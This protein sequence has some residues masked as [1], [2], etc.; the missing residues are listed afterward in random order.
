MTRSVIFALFLMI[1]GAFPAMA[2]QCGNNTK[3]NGTSIT[4]GNVCECVSGAVHVVNAD[5]TIDPSQCTYCGGSKTKSEQ[6]IIQNDQCFQ[7][8]QN[9]VS[10]DSHETCVCSSD[11]FGYADAT[12][13]SCVICNNKDN[14]LDTDGVCQTCSGGYVSDNVCYTCDTETTTRDY[15][16]TYSSGYY[17]KCKNSGDAYTD[18]TKT[19]CETCA[20]TEIVDKESSSATYQMCVECE[21]GYAAG[22]VCVTCGEGTSLT[23][24]DNETYACTCNN[25]TGVAKKYTTANGKQHLTSC[26]LC[27]DDEY[28]AGSECIKCTGA[29]VPNANKDACIACAKNEIAVNGT[30]EPCPNGYRYDYYNTQYNQCVTC[31]EN[32]TLTPTMYDGAITGYNCV[33]NGGYGGGNV[34]QQTNG[35]GT[36]YIYSCT[37]CPD[38]QYSVNGYCRKCN[39]HQILNSDKTGCT[40]CG[41]LEIAV[42]TGTGESYSETCTAC[43]GNGYF[44]VESSAYSDGICESC[45][46]REQY[47]NDYMA[48]GGSIYE[49]EL[50]GTLTSHGTGDICQYG[51]EYKEWESD[52]NYLQYHSFCKWCGA[53]Q[54][55]D[56]NNQCVSCPENQWYAGQTT[57]RNESGTCE[58]DENNECIRVP[59]CRPIPTGAIL[60]DDAHGYKCE[61]GYGQATDQQTGESVCRECRYNEEP[62]DGLCQECW[63]GYY[64]TAAGKCIDCGE[65]KTGRLVDGIPTCVC[66]VN[67][68]YANDPNNAGQCINC[69][70]LAGDNWAVYLPSEGTDRYLKSQ[71]QQC[72]NNLV[73]PAGS[74]FYDSCECP[75]NWFYYNGYS[76]NPTDNSCIEKCERQSESDTNTYKSVQLSEHSTQYICYVCGAGMVFDET[77]GLCKCGDGYAYEND[78]HKACIECNGADQFEKDGVCNTCGPNMTAN[79]DKKVCECKTGFTLDS[80]G[81]KCIECGKS[82]T[83]TDAGGTCR[84]CPAGTFSGENATYCLT[85]LPII[86]SGLACDEKLG[87]ECISTFQRHTDNGTCTYTYKD[88]GNVVDDDLITDTLLQADVISWAQSEACSGDY[89]SVITRTASEINVTCKMSMT[90][91]AS[92]G[93]IND[94]RTG[95]T[96][97]TEL[98][99]MMKQTP[100]I[101]VP[102]RQVT[103]AG[104]SYWIGTECVS[105]GTSCQ[106]YTKALGIPEIKHAVGTI[107][108]KY[109][110]GSDHFGEDVCYAGN[111]GTVNT[112]LLNCCEI[113]VEVSDTSEAGAGALNAYKEGTVKLIWQNS[114]IDIDTSQ[115]TLTA[116][117]C[118]PGATWSQGMV[119]CDSVPVGYYNNDFTNNVYFCPRGMTT[120]KRSSDDITDCYFG[121]QSGGVN[122]NC[123][124][125]VSTSSSPPSATYFSGTYDNKLN[126]KGNPICYDNRKDST[127]VYKTVFIEMNSSKADPDTVFSLPDGVRVYYR[128]VSDFTKQ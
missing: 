77:L 79:K 58:R 45:G 70:D 126:D 96:Y 41:P 2:L 95:K 38:G 43:P 47:H 5:N 97:E 59:D 22:T 42:K 63:R 50:C 16:Y 109:L 57:I 102:T 53:N 86:V 46:G 110:E 36:G 105:N 104:K 92:T 98:S 54:Y 39:N 1:F 64:D 8:G 34:T 81:E 113:A 13:T 7:C 11:I 21:N 118:A 28:V 56:E 51:G 124:T 123:I 26:K 12:K 83:Y 30:C 72:P 68:W 108:I 32:S 84:A 111:D 87:N 125:S 3:L 80:D 78:E 122:S 65:G 33:C 52:S 18:A 24:L 55:A 89:Y 112:H 23:Q 29:T 91:D 73:L 40:E 117:T 101:L 44:T 62:K 128:P 31:D 85:C 76:N 6:Y 82:G 37:A 66:D 99:C 100:S 17:C 69:L 75:D 27:A 60:R 93:R 20:A 121:T 115:A 90:V 88:S 14:Y 106:N 10:D 127:E 48:V 74:K 107:K 61:D 15:N 49:D 67:E 116:K 19:S 35:D 71:C 103:I 114:T 119:S 9:M 120:E 25:D 4:D 94:E